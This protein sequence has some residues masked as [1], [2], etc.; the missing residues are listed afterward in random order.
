MPWY[1]LDSSALVKRYHREAGS[2]AV[3]RLFDTTGNRF[4]VSRL[5]LVEVRSTFARL[6]R[7]AVI[8]EPDFNRLVLRLNTDVGAGGIAVAAVSSG[9]LHAASEILATHGLSH[10]IRTLDAIHLATARALHRRRHLAGLVAADK[11]MLSSAVV[12][13]GL[14]AIDVG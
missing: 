13:C 2:D 1:F 5:A 8:S 6:V 10:P 14:T 9:I 4:L 11:R 7:E 3:M 12:A